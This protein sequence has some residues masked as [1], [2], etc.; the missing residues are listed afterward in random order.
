MACAV[1]HQCPLLRSSPMPSYVSSCMGG[2]SISLKM[3]DLGALSS[4][5]S[6]TVD[7]AHTGDE[8]RPI[9]GSSHDTARMACECV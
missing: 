9:S 6:A 4:S 8:A 3:V 1:T 5:V 2:T 7:F